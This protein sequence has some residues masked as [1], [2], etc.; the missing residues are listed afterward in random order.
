MFTQDNESQPLTHSLAQK[1]RPENK[2]TRK[3]Q[4]ITAVIQK[5]G[6]SAKLNIGASFEH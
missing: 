4:P 6:F 2:M 1:K 5:W 3:K